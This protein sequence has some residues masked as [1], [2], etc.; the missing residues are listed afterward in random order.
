MG[1]NP[2]SPTNFCTAADFFS[3]LRRCFAAPL[4][5]I[6]SRG[7]ALLRM[8]DGLPP[9]RAQQLPVFSHRQGGMPAITFVAFEPG[10]RRQQ[11]IV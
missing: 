11:S 6:A 3:S 8:A 9:R 4:S 10:G 2:S 5:C 7:A 1:S